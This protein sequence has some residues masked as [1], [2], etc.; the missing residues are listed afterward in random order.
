[1]HWMNYIGFTCFCHNI[2]VSM[3]LCLSNIKISFD[4][5]QPN[6]TQVQSGLDA[7]A[8]VKTHP[9]GNKNVIII[10]SVAFLVCCLVVTEE[11]WACVLSR[12]RGKVWHKKLKCKWETYERKTETA[13]FRLL[14]GSLAM[15]PLCD[16]LAHN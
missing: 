16:C 3:M 1:M 15:L 5:R 8:K 9:F 6:L 7:W 12:R 10:C 11:L 4:R 13:S 2:S 14:W